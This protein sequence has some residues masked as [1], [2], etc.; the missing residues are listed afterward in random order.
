[1]GAFANS[2]KAF[3]DDTIARIDYFK[4]GVAIRLFS[5]IAQD[6][7]VDTGR[8]RGNWITTIAHPST[9]VFDAIWKASLVM[10]QI[11]AVVKNAAGDETICFA[12]NLIYILLLEYGYSSQQPGGMV[13]RNVARILEILKD[14]LNDATLG[15]GIRSER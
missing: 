11:R 10:A 6:T 14:A 7:P 5:A 9:E 13:R 4:R 15:I 12:N 3:G 2:L 1:M 8:A